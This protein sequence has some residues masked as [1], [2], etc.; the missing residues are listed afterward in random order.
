MMIIAKE[1][2][3]DG[4]PQKGKKK[5]G[6]CMSKEDFGLCAIACSCSISIVPVSS[7]FVKKKLKGDDQRGRYMY[8]I[9]DVN[10]LF[11]YYGQDRK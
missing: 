8:A 5:R 4:I 11:V 10:T 2:D 3:M 6:G 1:D 7:T 9:N